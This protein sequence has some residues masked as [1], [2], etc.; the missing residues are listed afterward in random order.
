MNGDE[1]KDVVRRLGQI[2]NSG[3]L[4]QLD[5]I[6]SPDYIRHDP[7][8]L[9]KDIGREEYKEA[10]RRLWRAFPNAKWTL[11]DLLS[12]GDKVIGRWTFRGTHEGQFFNLPPTSKE[13]SYPIQ[14]IYRIEDGM[15]VED[16]HIFHSIGLWQTLIPEIGALIEQATK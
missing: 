4:D 11:Q 14:A 3:N 15:I 10:F 8:P 2:V 9:M 1:N 6:L 5:E 7:N 12:D 13:V 16:W